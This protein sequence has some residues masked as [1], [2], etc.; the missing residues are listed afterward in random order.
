MNF[1]INLT[2][3][4]N[5][6]HHKV[7]Y[8]VVRQWASMAQWHSLVYKLQS[9]IQDTGCTF[10]GKAMCSI[11]RLIWSDTI[12]FLAG[13]GFMSLCQTVWSVPKL[14]GNSDLLSLTWARP[15]RQQASLCSQSIVL[16]PLPQNWLAELSRKIHFARKFPDLSTLQ[17]T[18]T[19]C[20]PLRKKT[21]LTLPTLPP[22]NQ[23]AFSSLTLSVHYC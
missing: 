21:Y 1:Q 19:L 20:S 16:H 9:K 2:F 5:A 12:C 4:E 17:M 18:H 10:K 8:G 7:F 15:T 22:K 23:I 11:H 14:K 6:L 3:M 13:S